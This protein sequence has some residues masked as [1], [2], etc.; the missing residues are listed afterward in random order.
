MIRNSLVDNR[1]TDL[2]ELVSTP[3]FSLREKLN[4]ITVSV[5]QVYILREVVA[6]LL[7]LQRFLVLSRYLG[8]HAMF[9]GQSLRLG[10]N[11]S[12]ILTGGFF[13]YL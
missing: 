2:A 10:E 6:L 1:I 13:F 5:E 11:F 7:V 4:P 9:F 12:D 3:V 8:Q